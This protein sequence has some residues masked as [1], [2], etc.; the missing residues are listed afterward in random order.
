MSSKSKI[1]YFCSSPSITPS[2]SALPLLSFFPSFFLFCFNSAHQNNIQ[3]II[4]RAAYIWLVKV[5]QPC[6]TSKRQGSTISLHALD[7]DC[8]RTTA[9]VMFTPSSLK[10]QCCDLSVICYSPLRCDSLC[11]TFHYVNGTGS[12]ILVKS[13]R[14]GSLTCWAVVISSL[15]C[16]HTD[17]SNC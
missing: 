6:P 3:I 7:W 17:S 2:L 4:S 15:Y 12:P 16:C 5:R 13:S 14:Q 1:Y 8:W 11:V 9:P 10:L